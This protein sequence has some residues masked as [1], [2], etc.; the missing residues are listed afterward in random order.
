MN[1]TPISTADLTDISG[2]RH[3]TPVTLRFSDQDA[4]GHINNV[5]YA[6]YAE[7]G[8]VAWGI[9]LIDQS[10]ETNCDFILANLTIDYLREMHYPG[11]VE[12]GTRAIRLGNKSATVGQ[13]I[14]RDG[15]AMAIARC[16]IVFIDVADGGT[17]RVP[18]GVRTLIEADLNR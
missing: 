5:S 7:A 17:T 4:I 10:G 2:Y 8:R 14:F 3:L 13:G 1:D 16:T 15:I 9:D 18:D 11:T 6:A 12:V